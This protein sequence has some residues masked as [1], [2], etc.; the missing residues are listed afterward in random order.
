ML[1]ADALMERRQL[2]RARFLPHIVLGIKKLEDRRGSAQGLL[3]IVVEYPKLAHRLV[4]LENRDDEREEDAFR[5]E[6]AFNVLAAHQ[7]QEGYRDGAEN[8]HHRRTQRVRAHRAQVG[9]EQPPRSIAEAARLPGLHRKSLHDAHAG[10]GF[11]QNVLDLRQFVLAAARSGAHAMTNPSRCHHHHRHKD[12][13]HPGQ[14]SAQQ[15]DHA[16]GEKEG[17]KLLQKFG[18]HRRQSK[19]YALDVVHNRRKQCARG[20]FLK[21]RHGAPQR[22][23]VQFVAQIGDHAVAGVVR[24]IAATVVEDALQH[25]RGDQC[26]R[27]HRPHVVK[28]FRNEPVQ[29]DGLAG[30][31]HFEQGQ[32]VRLGG[33]IQYQIED[34]PDQQ[35]PEG[36]QQSDHGHGH[37]GGQ[38]VEPVRFEIAKQA[39]QLMH[40]SRRFDWYLS[41][42]RNRPWGNRDAPIDSTGFRC[43][44]EAPR[45]MGGVR[46]FP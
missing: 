11:L 8:V 6:A 38:H 26:K 30:H 32:V 39:A 23:R 25:R 24:Q 7:D 15:H 45:P 41:P 13:K 10:D 46:P 2:L 9:F 31:R 17:E 14:P 12:D 28:V 5:K 33:R 36:V 1:E 4:Q 35:Q 21:E 37:H 19:L 16:G 40:S 18:Q 27:N 20:I 44:Y 43:F 42:R 3:E 34:G 29:L 22:G